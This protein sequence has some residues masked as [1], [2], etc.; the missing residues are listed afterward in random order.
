ME[1]L[2]DHI[3][4]VVG[5][6]R[7]RVDAWDVVNEAIEGSGLRNTVWHNV[8]GPEY[9]DL[10]FQWA[11][12]ADPDALLFYNDYSAEGMNTKSDAVYDLVK[13][14]LERGVPIH[15]V[16]MQMHIALG[17]VPPADKFLENMDR[18]ADLGLQVHITELD[19]RIR[20][21]PDEETLVQQAEDYRE[22]METC[23]AAKGCTAF[24]TWGF[25]DRYSWI[26]SSRQGWGSALILDASYQPKPAYTALQD[27]LSEP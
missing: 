2:R 16:G 20:D 22:I 7:G 6:Y 5:R 21:D 3:T 15:G 26:P 25:T 23:L 10:A 19:V 8:I 1:V 14:M 27:A 18:L 12:E 13:G 11:H 24:I 4:T 9:L 17:Q